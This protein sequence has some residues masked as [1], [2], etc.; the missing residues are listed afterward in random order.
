MGSVSGLDTDHLKKE[1]SDK[2]Y[3]SPL[4]DEYQ[5]KDVLGSGNILQKIENIKDLANHNDPEIQR[6]LAFLDTVK[7]EPVPFIC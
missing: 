2:L 1:L 5:V 4:D 6:T 7:P 3:F